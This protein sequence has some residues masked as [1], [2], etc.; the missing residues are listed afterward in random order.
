MRSIR[1]GVD[2]ILSTL[3]NEDFA[4]S[5]TSGN[6]KS[7]YM[8]ELQTFTSRVC[9]EFLSN[10]ECK[11]TLAES[12]HELA[13]NCVDLFVLH[14]SLVR[15]LSVGGRSRLAFDCVTLESALEP[16]FAIGHFKNDEASLLRLRAFKVLLAA[17]AK[18]YA[19]CAVVTERQLPVSVCL[20]LLFSFGPPELKSPH[21]SAGWTINR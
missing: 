13:S 3:H 1:D 15:P 11:A 21:E 19:N 9:V 16:L 17:D 18:S 12:A 6:R 10:F 20:H 7:S 8:K 2:A 4:S 5:D 14:A